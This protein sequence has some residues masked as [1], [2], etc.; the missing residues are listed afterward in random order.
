MAAITQPRLVKFICGM[1]SA[2]AELFGLAQE[3]LIELLGPVDIVSD[4]LPFDFTT[5]YDEE[6]G[7][8]RLRKFLAF[9]RL[10]D[11]GE[12]AGV[13]RATNGL[14]D[15][16]AR[17]QARAQPAGPARPIN[18]DPGYLVQSR[19]I[20]ASMK[21]FAHRIYLADGVFAEVTLQYRDGW[22]ALPWTFPDYGSG[23]YF[24]FFDA[25]RARL[26]EQEMQEVSP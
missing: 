18:L 22:Q 11:P 23:R 24:P 1:I 2:R 9:E 21:D 13:K 4:V 17:A 15:F 14:E 16:F 8:P 19:L 26:R 12:L 5:Y 10:I 6:M 20:L 7:R 3:R 25:V